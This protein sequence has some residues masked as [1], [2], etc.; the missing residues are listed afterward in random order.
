M[1]FL[2]L[3][4][5]AMSQKL[6]HGNL[7]WATPAELQMA[8]EILRSPSRGRNDVFHDEAEI[9]WIFEVRENDRWMIKVADMV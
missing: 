1:I 3:S 7:Q 8:E 6:P 9:G 2:I 5:Y 4:G